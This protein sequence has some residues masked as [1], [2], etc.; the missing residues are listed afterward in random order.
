MPPIMLKPVN[1]LDVSVPDPEPPPELSTLRTFMPVPGSRVS[2]AKIRSRLPPDAGSLEPTLKVSLPLPASTVVG[3]P[4]K[5][6]LT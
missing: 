6:T 1:V 2:A 4:T 5:L 3:A